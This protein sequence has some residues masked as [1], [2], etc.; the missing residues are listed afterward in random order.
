VSRLEKLLERIR[1]NPNDVTFA[2]LRRLLEAESFFLDRITG[3]HHV[4]RRGGVIFV[5][6]VHR[7]RVKEV[8]VKRF[9]KILEEHGKR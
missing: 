1:R 2:D 7:N 3:S 8:Y 6:P 5:V 9:L 4:F